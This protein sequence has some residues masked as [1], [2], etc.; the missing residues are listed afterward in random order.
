M[1][2]WW[3]GAVG[4]A[5]KKLDDGSGGNDSS[6]AATKFQSV[7][8]VVGAASAV[9]ASLAEILPLSDTPGGPWK[10]YTLSPPL[11]K[12]SV[13]HIECESITHIFFADDASGS[14]LETLRYVLSEILP[15]A[16]RLQH[17]CL[18]TGREH[19]LG[20][21][22]PFRED[23]P[24]AGS[25]N[26]C[27]LLEDILFDQLQKRGDVSWSAHRPTVIFGSAG[28]VKSL[29]AYAAVCRKEGAPLRWPGNRAQWEGFFDASD[30]DL[31]AEQQIWAAV[32]PYAKD[33]AFNCSNGDVFK[34]KHMW[35]VLAEQF[36]V[37]WVGYESE[38]MSFR[39]KDAMEGKGEVWEEIVKE[40]ELMPTKLGEVG[41][42]ALV[43]EVFN[44]ETCCLDSMNKSKEHGFLG[45]RNSVYS[46]T[47]WIDKVKAA[48]IVP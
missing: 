4:A 11:L 43:D 40:N 37:E 46:F 18:Q 21:D 24:R 36:G 42:W 41:D 9:G 28:L 23:L 47:Y 7:G 14:N 2:W 10:V 30:A 25:K 20:H 1:S 6:A 5:R 8:L 27:H 13:E 45:F 33:E 38:D 17:V 22:P 26:P 16:K 12:Q 34:W 35:K 31:V 39:L 48:K 3:A 19:Y 15:S 32:D 29:C 44:A